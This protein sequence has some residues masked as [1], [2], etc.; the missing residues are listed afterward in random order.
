MVDTL[1]SLTS[2]RLILFVNESNN[3]DIEQVVSVCLNHIVSWSIISVASKEKMLIPSLRRQPDAILLNV[4]LSRKY[5]LSFV[6][7]RII[8]HLRRNSLTQFSPILLLIDTADWL[9]TEQLKS[10]GAA[11][12]IAKPFNPV[13]LPG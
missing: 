8:R 4:L 12:A 10:I 13:A 7:K 9:T 11:G 3:D 5:N 2:S 6:Q 1:N